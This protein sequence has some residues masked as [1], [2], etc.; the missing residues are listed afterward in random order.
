MEQINAITIQDAEGLVAPEPESK[1]DTM[2][3]VTKNAYEPCSNNNKGPIY[4]ERRLQIEEL[5]E[6]RTQKPRT[7]NKSKSSQDELNT[8]PNQLKVGDKVLLDTT[9][10]R[11]TTSEPNEEIPLTVLSI[12]PYGTVEDQAHGRALG[13][14]YAIGGD[15]TVRYGRVKTGCHDRATW[16]WMKLPK[17]HG[18]ETRSCLEIVVETENVTRT[19]GTP[20]PST[21]GRH[22]QNEHGRGPMYTGV[23]EAN[24]ARYDRVTQPCRMSSSRGK[25]TTVPASKKRKGAASSSGPTMEIRHPFLQIQLAN[26]VRA[27]LMTDP[28]GLFFEIVESTYLELTLELC[29]TFHLQTFM[30]NFDDLGTVQFHLNGLYMEESPSVRYLHAILANTLSERRESTGIITIHDA[31]FLWSMANV[32]VIDLAYFIAFTIRHQTER[33]RREAISIGPYMT[34]LARHFGLLNT[35]I[36]SM[37]SIRMIEKRHGTYLP[38]YRLAQSTEE[39]DLEDIPNDVPPRHEDPPTQPPPPSR[40]VHAV[41]SYANISERLTRFKQQCFQ[42]FDNIDTTLQQIC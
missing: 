40:P 10:P 32:H 24:E 15:T 17:Q 9:D 18:H 13:H 36:S 8:S 39:E 25:K 41:A 27:F 23:G 29:S 31:Y 38:Q 35:G 16:S 4:E 26:A 37:L 2:E 30:T 12:F 34:Q 1:Q 14:A 33:H 7:P 11:I 6:W 20:V 3:I 5:D 21:C 19:C 22:C 28:W 42:R